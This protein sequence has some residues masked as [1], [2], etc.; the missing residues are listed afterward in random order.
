MF[1]GI[2]CFTNFKKEKDA[3]THEKFEKKEKELAALS[4]SFK[5]ALSYIVGK[6]HAKIF[7]VR[8]SVTKGH[9]LICTSRYH[10]YCTV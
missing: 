1:N 7:N 10:W 4:L 6:L 9:L 8:K 3:K 5:N 2:S